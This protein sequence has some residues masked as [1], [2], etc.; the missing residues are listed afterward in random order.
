MQ[1]ESEHVRTA[2]MLGTALPL[3]D[4]QQPVGVNLIEEA[5]ERRFP[6]LLGPGPGIVAGVG[7]VSADASVDTG[8]V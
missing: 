2:R 5:A 6:C 1:A 8:A 4:R 3:L 7:G